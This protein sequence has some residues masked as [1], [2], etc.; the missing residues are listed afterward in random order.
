MSG[1]DGEAGERTLTAQE[2]QDEVDA[3]TTQ[4]SKEEKYIQQVE[5]LLMRSRPEGLSSPGTQTAGLTIWFLLVS[6]SLQ[7]VL[8]SLL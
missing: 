2:S 5:E 1:G 8:A 4:M 3:S 7:L 6:P